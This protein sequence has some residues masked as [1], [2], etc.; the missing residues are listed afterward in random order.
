MDV[1]AFGTL[2]LGNQAHRLGPDDL[3][4]RMPKQVLGLLLSA[5]GHLMS[6][7]RLIDG[8]W[9]DRLPRHP[10]AA[11]EN[12]VWVLRQHLREIAGDAWPVV[13][14]VSQ[15]YRFAVE[16]IEFDLDRFDALVAPTQDGDV[17]RSRQRLEMALG[18]VRGE[19]FEDEPYAEWAASLRVTYNA[20]VSRVRLRLA[21][22]ALVQ[23]DADA[24]VEQA[25]NVMEQEPLNERACQLRILGLARAGLRDQAVDVFEGFRRALHAEL[26]LPPT[27]ETFGVL[28]SVRHGHGGAGG[29]H[30]V[31][32]QP[33]LRRSEPERSL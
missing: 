28:E 25:G 10:V 31:P 22:H 15:A 8:L 4:G 16:Q 12:H 27:A 29:G 11:L 20:R 21:E 24:A 26:G 7:E 32:Q 30:H 14:T 9:A 33:P 18:L 19:L 5:R 23:G 17:A 6:K 2:E 1:R 13:I 3:G